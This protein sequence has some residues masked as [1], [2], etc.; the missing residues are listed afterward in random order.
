MYT[1]EINFKNGKL[2]VGSKVIIEDETV[3]LINYM[4]EKI[5][6][7]KSDI[8]TVIEKRFFMGEVRENILFENIEVEEIEN[9]E[10]I[11]ILNFIF[12]NW[13][14]DEENDQY[15]IETAS[16]GYIDYLPDEN[17]F[18]VN[19]GTEKEYET[20][21]TKI[22][23]IIGMDITGTEIEPNQTKISDITILKARDTFNNSN[24]KSAF[25]LDKKFSYITG[26]MSER[27]KVEEL[28]K[29][30]N[31]KL[32]LENNRYFVWVGDKGTGISKLAAKYYQFIKEFYPVA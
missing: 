4:R 22:A 8:E 26:V 28:V 16:H 14:H 29:N 6:Y 23:S 15:W 21:I 25:R 5:T 18:I 9:N 11:S 32:E 3:I 20:N 17:I 13:K 2:L 10:N 1:Y 30:S 24:K 7:N 12:E 31:S 27:E 19:E